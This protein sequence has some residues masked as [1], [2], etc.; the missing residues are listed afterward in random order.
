MID[1]IEKLTC[2]TILQ[3]PQKIAVNGKEYTVAPPCVATLIEVSKYISQIP[4]IKVASDGAMIMEVLATAKDCECFGD[5]V[6]I[7]ILGKK[8][9]VTEKKYLWL[10]RRTV[11]NQKRLAKELLNTLT[12]E[13]LN[14]LILE[15]LRMLQVD[16]FFGISIFLRDIN[17]LKKTKEEATASGQK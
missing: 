7:L 13:E 14:N 11:D 4:E 8:N 6:A 16:F 17:Q 1:T 5:I 10:F 12:P 2:D 9:L 3:N 15:I